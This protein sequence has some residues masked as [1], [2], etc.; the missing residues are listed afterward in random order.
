MQPH[1]GLS[2]TRALSVNQLLQ[3]CQ[4]NVVVGAVPAEDQAAP[5]AA[6]CRC[7][8]SRPGAAP[9]FFQTDRHAVG[10]LRPGPDINVTIAVGPGHDQAALMA[11]ERRRVSAPGLPL[12]GQARCVGCPLRA[13]GR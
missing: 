8:P 2:T 12:A 10:A 13:G 1:R 4:V 3:A 7:A 5:M 11:G 6:E 9:G